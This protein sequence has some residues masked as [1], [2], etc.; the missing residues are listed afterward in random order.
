MRILSA[1]ALCGL[2]Y[3]AAP[4]VGQERP[5]PPLQGPDPVGFLRNPAVQ[6]ELKL[7]DEQLKKLQEL[8]QK[9]VAD[10]LT[11]EQAKRLRQIQLQQLGPDAF[12]DPE[13]DKALSLN[14]EQKQKVRGIREEAG[15]QMREI[16][17]NAGGNREEA[18]KKMSAV[19][20]DLSDKIAAVLSDDQKKVWKELL[21]VPFEPRRE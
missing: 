8:L 1:V 4:A 12:N 6:K 9:S 5:R 2:M 3:L 18:M 15:K 17:Q 13:V 7:S 16:F 14:D 19:R 20:K 10:T 21:G 11:P